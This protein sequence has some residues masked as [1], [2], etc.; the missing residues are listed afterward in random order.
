MARPPV[1]TLAFEDDVQEEAKQCI[2]YT[3]P[4]PPATVTPASTYVPATV[5][6]PF[7]TTCPTPGVYTIPAKTLTITEETTVC[8]PTSTKC[9]SGT[10]TAGGV[11]TVVETSTTVVCPYAT[12]TVSGGVTT[13]TILTT[14]YVCPSAGTYTIAP[15]TT[16]VSTETVW[17][18]PTVT[19]YP[20]G[21]YTQNEVIETV[22]ETDYV[23]F[24]PY[25]SSKPAAPVATYTP[26]APA[27]PKYT[28]A[29]SSPGELGNSGKKWAITYSPYTSSGECKSPGS[30]MSDI[31]QIAN[32]GYT[33]VRLYGSACSGLENVGAACQ[34]YGLKM[35]IGVFIDE[36]GLTGMAATD[37]SAILAWGKWSLVELIV[38]GNEAV[39]NNYCSGSEL[40]S[41]ITSCK[42][43]FSN[44]GYH[45]PCTT[46]EPLDIL[47][48][49]TAVICEVID[50][51]GCNIH[52]Y[53]NGATPAAAAGSF[54][55]GQLA[56][57]D[58]LCPGKTGINLETGWP[59]AGNCIGVSCPSPANQAIAL[60]SIADTV[61]GKSCV[62]SFFDDLWKEA[63]DC[64]CETS[65]G[66]EAIVSTF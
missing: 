54:V 11:T 9:T 28:P 38:I 29:T 41:F 1:R 30:V 20:V 65:F 37:V 22:T 2:V 53:F 48:A 17:V 60:Q 46:T 64:G 56:L 14:T 19:S 32:S 63:G 21:T 4:A 26:A 34:A 7:V 13:S 6:T 15:V 24:C 43:Q 25:T 16:V 61:G 10:N 50:V 51:V 35:I 8:A 55:A 33:T 39:F 23:I 44:A 66:I 27:A 12:T 57:V 40:A 59:S 18:Y 31:Q 36:T 62:L 45:G 52:P 47:Q 58:A 49:N 42:T 5:P 3:P